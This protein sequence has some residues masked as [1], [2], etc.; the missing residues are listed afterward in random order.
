VM[1]SHE[2]LI[3]WIVDRLQPAWLSHPLARSVAEARIN[4]VRSGSW[5]GIADFLSRVSS[6]QEKQFVTEVVS[7]PKPISDPEKTLKG[8]PTHSDKRGILERL[9]DEWL[10]SELTALK[11]RAAHPDTSD[12]ERLQLLQQQQSL[13]QMKKQ[14]LTPVPRDSVLSS[15]TIASSLVK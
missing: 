14:L 6:D 12:D 8:D 15:K 9:R 5:N 3:P 2:E 10:N 4:A 11:Q 7:D 13:R 1:L